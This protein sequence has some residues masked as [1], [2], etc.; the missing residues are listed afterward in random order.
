MTRGDLPPKVLMDPQLMDPTS[1]GCMLCADRQYNH[2]RERERE[3]ERERARER[4]SLL[5]AKKMNGY[6]NMYTLERCQDKQSI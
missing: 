5:A 1:V 4:E 3:R 6:A 2:K